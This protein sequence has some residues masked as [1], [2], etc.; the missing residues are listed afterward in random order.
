MKYWFTADLHFDHTNVITYAKRPFLNADGKPDVE[1]MNNTM[2]SMWNDSVKPEDHVY[3]LGDISLGSPE[4]AY[5]HVRQL[6]GIKHLVFGNHDKALRKSAK[7][8]SLFQWSRDLT[9]IR[10]PDETITEGRSRGTQPIVL[11]HYAMRVWNK[12]HHG[13]WQ[14]YGHSHGSLKDDPYSRQIDVG[15]TSGTTLPS[16]TKSSK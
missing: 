16:R 14:L 11:C 4:R 9:E 10:V 2:I 12:S 5:H 15:S 6:H 1:M 3:V 8:L 7:F 13:A